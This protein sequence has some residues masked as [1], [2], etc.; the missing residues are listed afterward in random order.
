[1]EWEE[2]RGGEKD[3]NKVFECVCVRAHTDRQTHTGLVIDT[4]KREG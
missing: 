4:R 2:M 3:N 1:M